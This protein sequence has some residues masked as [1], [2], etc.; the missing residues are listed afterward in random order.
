MIGTRIS[1]DLKGTT[2]PPPPTRTPPLEIISQGGVTN[3]AVAAA[4]AAAMV[5][6]KHAKFSACE[7]A[8]LATDKARI[9]LASLRRHFCRAS[10]RQ[11]D[12]FKHQLQLRLALNAERSSLRRTINAWRGDTDAVA[13]K[14]TAAIL[15]RALSLADRAANLQAN[16]FKIADSVQRDDH[17]HMQT[18][19]KASGSMREA[20]STLE[21]S[22][23]VIGACSGSGNL[24]SDAFGVLGEAQTAPAYADN[25]D[26]CWIHRVAAEKNNGG[27]IEALDLLFN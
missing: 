8:R 22:K 1:C 2:T 4:A 18:L 12:A 21:K 15:R 24:R 16:L 26:T 17:A 6:K 3:V 19:E 20:L 14:K 5:S 25:A 9:K 7:K 10:E 11:Q 13:R 27:R 23:A